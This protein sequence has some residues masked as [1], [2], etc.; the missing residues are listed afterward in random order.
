MPS[1]DNYFG[2]VFA[3]LAGAL[4]VSALS[5]ETSNIGVTMYGDASVLMKFIG[6]L[7]IMFGLMYGVYVTSPGSLPKYAFFVAFA[8]WIGQVIKPYVMNLQDKGTLTRV[9]IL[10]TGV[11]L[12]MMA[13]GFYDSMNLLGFGPYLIAGLLGLIVAQLL[14]LALGTPEEKKKGFQLLNF[15]GVALF[16]VFTAYDV[17]VMRDDAALC[18][19]LKKLKMDPDYP[20][21]SLGLYLDFI[22]LFNNMGG[23][24]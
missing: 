17:Q 13:L 16:A 11:F 21:A 6:N 5:A 23:G 24:D 10:T 20:V 9:L 4:A 2:K 7:A 18:K 19:R 1:C 15:F 12:G 8:F 22:N 14:L 3:H